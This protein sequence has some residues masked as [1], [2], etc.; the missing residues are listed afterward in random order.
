MGHGIPRTHSAQNHQTSRLFPRHGPQ[1]PS[2][3]T[4]LPGECLSLVW[5]GKAVSAY[6]STGVCRLQEIL[7][8]VRP[9]ATCTSLVCR[10]SGIQ[11]QARQRKQGPCRARRPHARG[12][13]PLPQSFRHAKRRGRASLR[14]RKTNTPTPLDPPLV[15]LTGWVIDRA[16]L[17]LRPHLRALR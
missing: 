3:R 11:R 10:R 9:L 7:I 5:P 16:W 14:E 1:P 15:V 12:L 2:I 6:L 13:T 17:Y 8:K 4:R